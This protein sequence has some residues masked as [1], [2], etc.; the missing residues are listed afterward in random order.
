VAFPGSSPPQSLRERVALDEAL[1]EIV[2]LG[3]FLSSDLTTEEPDI[4]AASE[5]LWD[6]EK[7]CGCGRCNL[8]RCAAVG[9]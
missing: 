9:Q 8:R 5:G 3:E 1:L 7:L 6:Q 4:I 2:G